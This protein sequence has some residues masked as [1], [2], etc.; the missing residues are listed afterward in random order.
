V[1]VARKDSKGELMFDEAGEQLFEDVVR[2]VKMAPITGEVENCT[3]V[4]A[5]VTK[6]QGA[7]LGLTSIAALLLF[8]LRRRIS[9]TLAAGNGVQ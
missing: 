7:S 3:K 5:E 6:R 4:E 1:K 8:G 9:R 2:A